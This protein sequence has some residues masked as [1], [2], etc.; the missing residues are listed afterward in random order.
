M[1][2][3]LRDGGRARVAFPSTRDVLLV[4]GEAD[5]FTAAEAP[6][7]VAGA[8]RAKYGWDPRGDGASY[9]FFRVR[10][11]TVQAYRGEREMRGRFLMREGAWTV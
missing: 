8:L 7:A 6:E 1:R 9:A 2:G 4:D 5:T 10:P 11:R 3:D